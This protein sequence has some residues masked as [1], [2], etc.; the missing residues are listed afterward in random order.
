MRIPH[1]PL[2]VHGIFHH[3]PPENCCSFLLFSLRYIC[4]IFSFLLRGI[5][6]IQLH[7]TCKKPVANTFRGRANA[8]ANCTFY[9]VSK[10]SFQYTYPPVE[11]ISSP[12]K[13]LKTAK[14]RFWGFLLCLQDLKRDFFVPGVDFINIST[15]KHT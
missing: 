2:Q 8:C 13:A 15:K 11:D 12:K 5:V 4:S 3:I 1:A 6:T 14:A 10:N 9:R 7:S